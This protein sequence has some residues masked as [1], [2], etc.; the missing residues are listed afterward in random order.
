MARHCDVCGDLKA[1]EFSVYVKK[2]RLDVL[3]KSANSANSG[4][5]FCK[6]ITSA[7]DNVLP[8]HKDP[9]SVSIFLRWR[10]YSDLYMDVKFGLKDSDK[11]TFTIFTTSK[12][13]PDIMPASQQS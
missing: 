9:S 7:I 3:Y 4:C 2:F 5:D 10:P 12:A 8:E 13:R 11:K 6:I 1:S